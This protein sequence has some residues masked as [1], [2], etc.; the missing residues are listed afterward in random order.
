[1]VK[2]LA[3]AAARKAALEPGHSFIVQA[4]AGS[5]KTGLLTQRYLVLLARVTH[6]EEVVAVTFTRKAAAEM[7]DRVL[8][9]LQEAGQAGDDQ[10][11]DRGNDHGRLTWKLGRAVLAHDRRQ[12]WR[13]LENPGRLRI[14]TIDALCATIARQMPVVSGL[15]G[16]PGM[17]ESAGT[18]YRAAARK[19]LETLENQDRWSESTAVLL[20][21]LDNNIS[22]A[23]EMLA[24]MLARREQWLRHIGWQD[25]ETLRH[26]L[27]STLG[28]A[29]AMG[30][31]ATT[32]TIPTTIRAEILAVARHAAKHLP[33]QKQNSPLSPWREQ[34]VFPG[35]ELET[36][37]LWQGLR[38]LFFTGKGEWRKRFDKNLGFPTTAKGM[39]AAEKAICKEMK[40]RATN[41]VAV[42]R[43]SPG[44]L[45]SL[46]PLNLL[47][48][49]T[50][51]DAQWR[52]LAA[53]L[54]LLPMAVAQLMVIFRAQGVTDF[55]EM[56]QAAESALG[57]PDEPTDLALRL[58]YRLQHLLV[59]EFQ[60][61]SRGQY[62]L[63][64]RLTAGWSG[65]DGRTLF[66]VG[67]PMQSIYRFREAEVGLFLRARQQ[68]IGM[69][70]LDPLLLTVNF[71]SQQGMVGWVNTVFGAVLA[72]REDG[73][74]GAVP[75]S[76]SIPFH[77]ATD[78]QAV[79]VHPQFGN[80][81]AQEAETVVTLAAEARARGERVAILG[82]SRSHLAA[83]IPVLMREKMRFQ[84]VDIEALAGLSIIQDLLALARAVTHPAD[85]I[86]WLALLR[87]PW[88][89]LTLKDMQL[90]A[91][92]ESV[93]TV[94]ECLKDKKRWQRLSLD[95]RSRLARVMAVLENSL[96]GRRRIGV[97]PGS[98]GLRAL[99]EST[100]ES[101]GGPAVVEG[102]RDLDD[103]KRFFDLLG[104]IEVA[105]ELPD[106]V[107]FKQRV[108]E[109]FGGVDPE[110]DPELTLMTIHKAK[111]LEFDTVILPGLGRRSRGDDSP[112][113]AW[114]EQPDGLLLAPIKRSD[115]AEADPIHRYL[116][117][118]EKKRGEHETGRLLYVA[119]TRAKRR[120]HLLGH[121]KEETEHAK[122]DSG[123]LLERLWP[124]L[125]ADF[126]TA[127]M[128]AN[129]DGENLENVPQKQV[130]EIR[131]LAANWQ[132]PDPPPGVRVRSEL[133]VIEEEPVLFEWAGEMARLMGTVAHRLLK[134]MA[135]EGLA[136][137][138]HA[139]V[140]KHAPSIQAHL[141]RLGVPSQR[142]P[143]AVQQVEGVL[144]ATLDDPRGR[145]VL[146][147]RHLE[148]RSEYALSGIM[149]GYPLRVVLDR[150][151]ID[152]QGVRWIIDFK[153][154]VHGGCNVAGFLDNE[155]K[156]YQDQMN[157]YGQLM[158]GLDSRPIRL[159]LYF[160]LL[161]G[162]R[163]WGFREQRTED[164]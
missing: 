16:M 106:F 93:A 1:M 115:H 33:E 96:N 98:S 63:L 51:S 143:E 100:W 7:R 112:L 157:R 147:D 25:D 156:R 150:T 123:S 108:S 12:S 29:V 32:A 43:E 67:D 72:E 146:D 104:T 109:L 62:R 50:Y 94:W 39:S 6:P 75:F 125:A 38:E 36:L 89:G 65:E 140:K 101:L 161:K 142:L 49:P 149:A 37:P 71:R 10:G 120:L 155:Q 91:P 116:R 86:A 128:S 21:H 136:R 105:G 60:D 145:W 23:E 129:G 163:E 8:E 35:T 17:T 99:V 31:S 55:T 56:A 159:G 88:C 84:A 137:W 34:H 11:N 57:E 133:A 90:L 130:E 119:V 134:I 85:R 124:S 80:N 135:G 77:P 151:F 132:L 54:T 103:A 15:G 70:T 30:L 3:D 153:T 78:G 138:T 19:T 95:G 107:E 117:S 20:D 28:Q 79:M 41:L 40:T 14:L 160:P 69:V 87:A 76:A 82:R 114:M 110:G 48:N 73:S 113:L 144:L 152:D 58:D 126:N 42:L 46:E 45:D 27:E 5:G 81:P 141:L 102:V 24:R 121:V 97:F 9:A 44:C 148:G 158:R 68:G 74:E 26:H 154:S 66:L 122:P 18:L 118:L 127:V 61:T 59:D 64:Q 52:I 164:G 139:R 4:P 162:W 53:L 111:G 13:L 47:P 131:R 2:E 83:I 92:A 22:Q